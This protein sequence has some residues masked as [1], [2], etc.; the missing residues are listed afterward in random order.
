MTW[1]KRLASGLK[2][3][4]NVLSEG[5]N[6]LVFHKKLDS[7]TLEELEELLISSDI[8]VNTVNKI[9]QELAKQKFD[10]QINPDEVRLFVQKKIASIITPVSKQLTIP[11]A[12]LRNNLPYVIVICGVNGNGKTT[13]A[14]KLAM[15]FQDQGYS[16]MM[17]ACDTF[18]AAAVEQL[19]IWA[20]RANKCPIVT[21]D[22]N[23]D[24]AS[25][26]YSA[27]QRA[28]KANIDVLLIDTAGRLHNNV[29]LMEELS[30]TIRVLKKI[31][32]KAPHEVVLVIDATT[33]QNAY[34]QINLFKEK[35]DISGV[36]V[37]KL[38]TG[39]KGGIVVGIADK[40]NIP[41]YA[42]GIGEGI[43][44]LNSFDP[45]EFAKALVGNT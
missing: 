28:T 2:K 14:G 30:K 7:L 10:K 37:T 22:V 6:K 5:I 1:L 41:I 32:E 13:T 26:A 27:L 9:T 3:T 12:N 21:G 29:N 15:Q 17:A 24:P 34:N 36:I 39:A 19:S 4:S 23:A 44:D 20:E 45:E 40:Y 42:I 11:D 43:N 18:R 31:D 35:A 38:D 25:V 16:V 33:G 8:G